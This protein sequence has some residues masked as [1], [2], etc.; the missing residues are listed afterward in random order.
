MDIKTTLSLFW[1][2]IASTYLALAVI[3]MKYRFE[4]KGTL[5]NL[6]KA[7]ATVG[8][9]LVESTAAYSDKIAKIN[10]IGFLIASFAA[11]ATVITLALA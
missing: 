2:V 1:S 5:S 4:H 8:R 11:I 3:S 6:I 9:E 7:A 10:S